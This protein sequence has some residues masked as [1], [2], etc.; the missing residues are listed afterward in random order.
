MRKFII[1]SDGHLRYG[2]VN[3]HR[4][5]LQPGDEC[6]GGGTYE[7]DYIN[8]RL[9]LSGKSYDYGRPKWDWIDT[10]IVPEV[11]RGLDITYDG[12]PLQHHIT[13]RYE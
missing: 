9:C 10:I 3:M 11:F 13:V 1:T 8:G 6:I 7:F 12:I 4:D 5:L 2:D